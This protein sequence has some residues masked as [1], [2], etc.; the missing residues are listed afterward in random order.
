MIAHVNIVIYVLIIY[1]YILDKET[2]LT[3]KRLLIVFC[4][5]CI[6]IMS[7]H[8]ENSNIFGNF[9]CVLLSGFFTFSKFI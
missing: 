4:K 7:F 9:L 6:S 8:D 2:F 1:F 3:E 5:M